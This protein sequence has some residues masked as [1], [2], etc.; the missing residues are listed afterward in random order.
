MSKSSSY[1]VR[2]RQLSNALP[3]NDWDNNPD[4]FKEQ[5]D[6]L[7]DIVSPK[8]DEVVKIVK[9]SEGI[10]LLYSQFTGIGGI[11]S[12]IKKLKKNGINECNIHT[13]DNIVNNSINNE[14]NVSDDTTN[15]EESKCINNNLCEDNVNQDIENNNN[16][17]E[18]KILGNNNVSIFSD[19][20]DNENND[21]ENDIDNKILGNNDVSI[22]DDD[23]KSDIDNNILGNNDVS[24]FG[25][26]DDESDIDPFMINDNI[27]GSIFGDND[28]IFAGKDK[29]LNNK[30]DKLQN[31]DNK[32]TMSYAVIDGSIDISIR[33]KIQDLCN[34]DKN[35]NGELIKILLVSE[36]G[37]EGLDLKNIRK[38]IQYEPYWNENRTEQLK[39]RAHRYDSH[40]ML[41]EKD[42]NIEFYML[43]SVQPKL[44]TSDQ[45][46]DTTTD[47]DLYKMAKKNQ[48]SINS[49]LSAYIEVGIECQL[50]NKSTCKI[51]SPNNQKLF[52]NDINFD[53]N[54]SNPCRP[55]QE[56]NVNVS[57]ITHENIV[58]YYSKDDTSIYDYKI[59]NFDNNLG[60]YVEL[61]ENTELFLNILDKI[62]QK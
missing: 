4:K 32:N 22:F 2:S 62:K 36:T 6:K 55:I 12:I 23:N 3:P 8:A 42:R 48:I 25:S 30:D 39:S 14:I 35:I 33:K 27:S 50:Y 18:N 5:Y 60:G 19:D 49:F 11:A 9:N 29:L 46:K 44:A 28:E 21:D 37:T 56:E 40:I 51:C 1:R 31:D 58:Y 45:L 26:D 7:D 38:V 47:E 10:I 53:I 57:K 34:S 17:I 24:I 61:E 59:Y 41:P 43:L 54:N 20:N 52:T 13:F 16:D 15:K